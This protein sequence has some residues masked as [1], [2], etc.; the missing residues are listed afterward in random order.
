M[1]LSRVAI[2]ALKGMDMQAKGRIANAAGVKLSS[3]YRWVKQNHR[4]LTLDAALEQI[5]QETGLAK[6]EVLEKE[7][8]PQN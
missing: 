3:L 2:L 6:S 1:K 5:M 4:N 8:V 7:E